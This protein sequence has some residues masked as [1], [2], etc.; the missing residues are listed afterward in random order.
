MP[1]SWLVLA[2]LRRATDALHAAFTMAV[3]CFVRRDAHVYDLLT[4]YRP[5][6]ASTRQLE[7]AGM[8]RTGAPDAHVFSKRAYLV[9]VGSHRPGARGVDQVAKHARPKPQAAGN[10]K[11]PAVCDHSS[12]GRTAGGCAQHFVQVDPLHRP[13]LSKGLLADAEP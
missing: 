2:G 10:A 11:K 4:L 8:R 3:D 13:C 6:A 12:M 7:E 1:R 9:R 5:L